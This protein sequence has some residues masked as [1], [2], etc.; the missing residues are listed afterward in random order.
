MFSGR[1]HKE[2]KQA[3]WLW[4]HLIKA[5]TVC[6]FVVLRQPLVAIVIITAAKEDLM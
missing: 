6:V 1:P 2:N 3:G 4:K 5:R